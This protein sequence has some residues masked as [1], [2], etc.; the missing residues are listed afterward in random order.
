MTAGSLV[1]SVASA[2]CVALCVV[3]WAASADAAL[4]DGRMY[5]RVSSLEQYGGEVYAP[6]GLDDFSIELTTSRTDLPFQASA[7]G[8]KVAYL[9]SP[10]PGG[11]ELSG[12]K[13]GNEYL[14]SRQ[15][16]GWVQSDIAPVDHP[17]AVFQAFSSDLSEGFL[18]SVEPLS[19]TA[20][21]FGEEIPRQGS[22]DILYRTNT[23]G[24]EYAPMITGMPPYRSKESFQ[25]AGNAERVFIKDSKHQN[26]TLAFIG[27]SADS[28]HVLF[29]ANDALTGASEGRPA[30]EG[31]AGSTFE[32][33]DNLYES[34]DGQMQLVNILPNNTTHVNATFGG[35]RIPLLRY[36]HVISS[37]GSRVFWTD[38][39]T[40]HIYVRENG[41][42][43]VEVSPAGKYQTA[44]SNGSVAFYTNG[45]LYEYELEGAKTTDL[46]PGVP[47]ESVVGASVDGKYVYYVTASG[48]FKLWHEGVTTT[49]MT[50]NVTLGEVTPDGHSVVFSDEPIERI[51][52]SPSQD[53]VRVY[54][55][56]TNVLY[57][58]SC[59]AGGTKGSLPETNRGNVYQPRW[60]SSDGSRVFFA[61]SE[62]LVP[63]DTNG[64][65]DVYEWE[66]PGAG[67]CPAGEGEG[68]V[69]ILSEGT[70]SQ[71]SYF[72]DA[73]E[74]G[75]D[76][77]IVS[78]SKLGGADEDEL[79]DLYDVTTHGLT[80][81]A[82]LTCTGS[83][84]QGVPLSAPIFATPASVT[85]EGVGNFAAVAKESKAKPKPKKKP[86]QKKPKKK[87]K[88][89]KK[90]KSKARKSARKANGH[91][92]SGS[93]GGR[94]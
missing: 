58:A 47:V 34:V 60:M 22:Y 75:D 81:P 57:C 73:S 80:Q 63:S 26:R 94:S 66:R 15:S 27:A 32:K 5:E 55:A 39:A 10:S 28:S 62:A 65:Y 12:E 4:P 86:K 38:L 41:T 61:T 13:G 87:S 16:D 59:T 79:M 85:F 18:D 2:L 90:G 89:K 78:R 31:G 51:A 69:Y 33:A 88:G 76:V 20:P 71:D 93:K 44:S 91:G 7:D 74:S 82:P 8:S 36:S 64:L 70:G 23:A 42:S 54:D 68:C 52:T 53:P 84:C 50:T 43:T 19:S 92:R 40:G 29:M 14:A 46:T 56:S 11:N 1:R 67:S 49:I 37:D 45:D 77:F 17:G 83:G 72:V 48:E 3:V 21:G 25:T 35:G 30:A 24:S 6:G 9:G